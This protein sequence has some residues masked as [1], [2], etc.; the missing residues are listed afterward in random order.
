MNS[1]ISKSLEAII[2]R[3]A[4]TLENEGIK[5]SYIDRLVLAILSE[6]GS[7][8]LWLLR[9]MIGDCG[10][11]VVVRR[12]AQRIQNSPIGES[13][14]PEVRYTHMCSALGAMLA[15][16]QISTAHVLFLALLESKSATAHE[17][18][19]YGVSAELLITAIQRVIEQP[20][21]ADIYI[22]RTTEPS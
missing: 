7:F 1:K 9:E 21:R 13:V 5:D 11:R 15:V 2:M 3:T 4:F 8:A 10:V 18:Q 14:S 6:E 20:L 22:H 17:L 19:G 12:I 16:K